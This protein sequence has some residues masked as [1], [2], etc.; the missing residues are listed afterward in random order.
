MSIDDDD[1]NSSSDADDDCSSSDDVIWTEVNMW[2]LFAEEGVVLFLDITIEHTVFLYQK[3]KGI[4][5]HNNEK[6]NI[7][8][9]VT[10]TF[11]K[12]KRF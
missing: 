3:R 10:S 6:T 1:K 5:L 9:Q 4:I 12:L 7:P 11:I 8:Y 2:L